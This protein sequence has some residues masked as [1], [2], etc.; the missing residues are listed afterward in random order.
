MNIHS[1][2]KLFQDTFRPRRMRE[3]AGFFALS[4][5]H[6]V[7]DVGGDSENWLYIDQKPQLT[8]GNICVDDHEEDNIKYRNLDGTCIPYKDN[9]YDIAYSNSVIEH[10]GDWQKQS[11]FAREIRRIAPNYY[12]Q[13]PNRNFFIEPHFLV[14]LIHLL[15]RRM[16][17]SLLPFFSIWYW[18]QRPDSETVDAMFDEIRLLDEKDMREL[19]PDAEIRREKFLFFTKSLI[20]VRKS[21]DAKCPASMTKPASEMLPA[22]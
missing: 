15:P 7:I 2:Y 10:V 8:I 6:L 13:T 14:L 16:Y 18:V 22:E 9:S 12:V 20:A 1:V 4:D 11:D 19:F 17:R 21:G 3:F 5:E